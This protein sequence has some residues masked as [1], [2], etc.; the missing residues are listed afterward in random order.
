MNP[1]QVNQILIDS[2]AVQF[3]DAAVVA[4]TWANNNPRKIS[5]V[6]TS[7]KKAGSGAQKYKV[8]I[9]PDTNYL[10]VSTSYLGANT[11]LKAI[12]PDNYFRDRPYVTIKTGVD[13]TIQIKSFSVNSINEYKMTSQVPWLK[14][15]PEW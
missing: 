8:Y 3:A 11:I 10:E 6:S 5:E 2:G 9:N 13:Q 12:Y 1:I 7:F 4:Q 15:R 14:K